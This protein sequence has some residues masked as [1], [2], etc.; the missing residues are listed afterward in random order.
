MTTSVKSLSARMRDDI[1]SSILALAAPDPLTCSEALWEW[2]VITDTLTDHQMQQRIDMM[3][4]LWRE[5]IV[6]VRWVGE[7]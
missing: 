1:R 3:M 5:A 6:T 7:K 4:D 2:G